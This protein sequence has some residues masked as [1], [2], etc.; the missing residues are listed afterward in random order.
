MSFAQWINDMRWAM[1]AKRARAWRRQLM[2]SQ[3]E[4]FDR[5]YRPRLGVREPGV[6]IDYPDAFYHTD[7]DDL[8]RAMAASSVSRP[9]QPTPGEN[10]DER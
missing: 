1:N 5:A 3:R 8:C 10:H 7:I 2:F 9:H 6:V 4:A